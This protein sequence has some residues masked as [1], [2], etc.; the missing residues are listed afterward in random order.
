MKR[1]SRRDFI[2]TVAVGMAAAGSGLGARAARAKAKRKPNIVFVLADDL[3]WRDV[4]FHGAMFFETPNIDKLAREWMIFNQFYSG[5]PNCAPTRACI[6]TGMYS[7][8]TKLYTPGGKSKG[9][10]KLMR[11]LV[12]T[13]GNPAGDKELVSRN[14]SIL[15]E[16]TS[17]A[18]VLKSA[19]YAT[20]R[21]GK[22]HLGRDTQGFDVSSCNGKD[23]PGHKH[24]GSVTVAR[25]ITDRAVKFIEDNKDRPFF[26][27]VAHWDVH[28]PIRALKDV[29]AKYQKK[30]DGWNNTN[31]EKI[32]PTYAGMI[33][34][35]DTSVARLRAKLADLGL[36]KN[37]LFVFSSDNGGTQVTTVQ[38]LRG[39]KGALF[40]GGIRVSTCAAWPGVVAPGSTCDVP[41]TSVDF[42]PTFA[43]VAGAK[44]PDSQPVDGESF[45][46]LLRGGDKLTRESI[47][48]HF[49]LYLQGSRSAVVKPVFGT[50][51]PY[52]R[53]VPATVMRKGD[54]KLFYFYED[55]SIEL[56]NVRRDVGEKT[57]VAAKFPDRAAAM[58]T[59]LL[60][61]V[62]KTKAPTPSSVNP[63]FDP[64]ATGGGARRKGKR[65]RKGKQT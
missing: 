18:E 55:K 7:P 35:V 4:G 38:P 44:L 13:R 49:P 9:N 54:W 45:V 65:R 63:A 30:K 23:G 3:G 16:H 36:D 8:R 17:I 60:A 41:L 48:W 27:Y 37:T 43:E 25:T 20:A 52:W 11:L 19:G 22:W 58:K 50:D 21:I 12:P 40:E 2:K 53:G 51:R 42:M 34:A 33:E 46:T 26:L 1:I 15:P 6:M 31:A 61:W 57:D 28:G 56:Y 14:D 64:K 62:R 39:G 24:Y 10:P 32:N 59:E 47:F 5:G 29:V